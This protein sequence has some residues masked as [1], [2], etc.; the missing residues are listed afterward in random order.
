[1][2]VISSALKGEISVNVPKMHEVSNPT[3]QTS[4]VSIFN[5][6]LLATMAKAQTKDSVCGLVIQYVCKGENQ[7]AW[8]FQKLDVKPYISICYSLVNW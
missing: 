8:L 3:V 5:Q 6:V 4:A 2:Q 1:M 7:M